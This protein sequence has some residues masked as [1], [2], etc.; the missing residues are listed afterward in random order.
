MT[1]FATV[2]RPLAETEP[3][4]ADWL[5]GRA[6]LAFK[7]L[8]VVHVAGVVIAFFPGPLPVALLLA[9]AFNVAALALAL[10]YVLVARGIDRRRSWAI[11]S[12]R[13]LL[14]IVF[15]ASA[16]ET[17]AAVLD[18]RIKLPIAAA[19]ALWA[20]LAPRDTSL[21]AGARPRGVPSAVLAALLLA[22]QG[23]VQPVFGW[24][25]VLDV[26]ASAVTGTLTADCGTPGEGAPDQLTLRYSWSWTA[27]SPVPSGLDTVVVGWTGNNA[28]GLPLY[29]FDATPPTTPGIYEGRLGYP[30]SDLA[31]EVKST[32]RGSW[33]W[34]VEL[35]QH[36]FAPGEVTLLLERPRDV[37]PGSRLVLNAAYVHLGIWQRP[38]GEV[39]CTW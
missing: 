2:R 36:G 26:P 24:G 12:A 8:A 13:P 19:I 16:G 39:I 38:A 34:G 17:V 15:L 7:A 21:E 3:P 32:M 4:S 18:G 11:D 14:F 20:L 23:F 27:S 30:S 29:L 9:L 22:T 31:R 6:S 10:L 37:P 28:K 1:D 35:S 25:G 5:E 33:H